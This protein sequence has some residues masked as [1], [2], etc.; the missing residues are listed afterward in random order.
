MPLKITEKFLKKC[1]RHFL[2]IP[3]VSTIFLKVSNRCLSLSTAYTRPES[4]ITAANCVVFIP[5]AAH[6][7]RT[8]APGGGDKI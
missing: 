5:G 6:I 1:K 4:W 2:E 3:D 8:T 7:S